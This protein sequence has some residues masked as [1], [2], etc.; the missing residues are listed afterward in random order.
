MRAAELS[1]ERGLRVVGVDGD[2]SRPSVHG[3]PDGRKRRIR[4]FHVAVP[5]T[6]NDGRPVDAQILAELALGAAAT[7]GGVT[8]REASGLCLDGVTLETD[9]LLDFEIWTSDEKRI[10]E[11]AG[12]VA[13]Q[14]EQRSVCTREVVQHVRFVGPETDRTLSTRTGA[15]HHLSGTLGAIAWNVSQLLQ[16]RIAP[17]PPG[18]FGK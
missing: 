13:R 7:F 10:R 1:R 11:L 18:D 5:I 17:S 4:A 8:I 14:L 12:T 2:L 9:R 16:P 6:Y 3:R 15:W